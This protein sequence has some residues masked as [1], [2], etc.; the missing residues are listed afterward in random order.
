MFNSILKKINIHQKY[1]ISTLSGQYLFPEK[2][3]HGRIEDIHGE[4]IIKFVNVIPYLYFSCISNSSFLIVS[5]SK[6]TINNLLCT[7]MHIAPLHA[8]AFLFNCLGNFKTLQYVIEGCNIANKNDVESFNNKNVNLSEYDFVVTNI[9]DFLEYQRCAKIVFSN[10]VAILGLCSK[11]KLN[12]F[13]M[14]LLTKKS[15]FYGINKIDSIL[16][17][18]D[19]IN[20]MELNWLSRAEITDGISIDGLDMYLKN[21]IS[22]FN[23]DSI[24][25]S[26]L[27]KKY[28]QLNGISI[29]DSIK[30]YEKYSNKLQELIQNK[31]DFT[32]N[33][34]RDLPNCLLE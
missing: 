1:N 10:K 13:L 23:L 4:S 8:K 16:F 2:A 33:D 27:I 3:I 24:Q 26:K 15:V 5:E 11:L 28:S 25:N 7:Y 30:I 6:E 32:L 31:S 21:N 18:N 12:E 19:E 17:L 20:V 14:Q 22:L 29:K 34:I 9:N